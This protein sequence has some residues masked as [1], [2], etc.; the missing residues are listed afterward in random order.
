MKKKKINISETAKFVR[1]RNT[2][3]PQN[4]GAARPPKGQE[5]QPVA[6]VSYDDAIAFA[7]WRSKRDGVTYRLPTEE[8]WEYAARNGEQENIYPWGNSWE[9]DHAGTQESGVTAQPVGR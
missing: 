8:E 7:A 2:H 9:A 1:K 5:S 4:W 3:P 6:F